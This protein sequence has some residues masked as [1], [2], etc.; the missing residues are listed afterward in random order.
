MMI[1]KYYFIEIFKLTVKPISLIFPIPALQFLI[2]SQIGTDVES[3]LYALLFSFT[4]YPA[5]N[6][7]NHIN[8]VK[9]DLL[10]GKYN[11]FAE[12]DC[13]KL[14]GIFLV[15][16]MF[17]ISFFILSICSNQKNLGFV[18]YVVCFVVAWLYSDRMFVG[19]FVGRF[20]DHYVTELMSFVIFCPSF[21]LI[22]WTFFEVINVRSLM[23]SLTF[24]FFILF[25]VLLKDV[26]DISGDM[27]AGLKTLGVVFS[28]KTLLKFASLSILLYYLSILISVILNIYNFTS[29]LALIPF[30][31][32][33]H[34]V[35]NF[36][37]N[38]WSLAFKTV[39]YFRNMVISNYAS[40]SLLIVLGLLSQ[41]LQTFPKP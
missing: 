23:V 17:A 24:L 27:K 40:I 6:L 3:F 7:W 16:I 4:F 13:L 1:K 39:R 18:L 35:W 34:S 5:V 19:R 38:N 10:A 25:S 29:I 14:F 41:A 22:I 32:F 15:L 26:K 30:T 31:V 28:P 33:M 21:A 12:S 9:E 11:V 8:D 36:A 37:K 2:F 20:K